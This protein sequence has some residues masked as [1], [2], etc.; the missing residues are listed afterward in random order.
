MGK[1]GPQIAFLSDFPK[2]TGFWGNFKAQVLL[3]PS[4]GM[5]FVI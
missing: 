2:P 4:L 1:S 5:V 3:R